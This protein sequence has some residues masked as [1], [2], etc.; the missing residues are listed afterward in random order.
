M[1]L[2]FNQAHSRDHSAFRKV[3]HY[4]CYISI[5]EAVSSGVVNQVLHRREIIYCQD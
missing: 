5:L 4:S 3:K 1:T 2:S